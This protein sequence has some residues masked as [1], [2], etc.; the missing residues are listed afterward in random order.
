M[1][2][3]FT[4]DVIK[5]HHFFLS[6][7]AASIW[8]RWAVVYILYY[9]LSTSKFF[10]SIF[11]SVFTSTIPSSLIYTNTVWNSKI[12]DI[13]ITYIDYRWSWLAWFYYELNFQ[14]KTLCNEGKIELWK[15]NEN[16]GKVVIKNCLKKIETVKRNGKLLQR[17]KKMKCEKNE[18]R[19]QM[20]FVILK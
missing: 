5:L 2:Y 16:W 1:K 19:I 4:R 6:S 3:I 8:W 14:D 7:F 13:Q 17:R 18:Q 20:V 10:L 9:L 15:M 11:F 12:I